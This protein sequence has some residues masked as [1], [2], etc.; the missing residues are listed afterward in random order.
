MPKQTGTAR[1]FI[2]DT[3]KTYPERELQ[4]ADL[5]AECGGRFTLANLSTTV[6]RL[7]A[8]GLVVKTADPDRSAWWGIA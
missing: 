2:L 3:L 1:E 5:S 6:G 8:D 7:Q 4:V